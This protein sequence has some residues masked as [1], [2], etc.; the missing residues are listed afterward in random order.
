[1]PNIC[2]QNG[3]NLS[4]VP[5][6]LKL[7][8]LENQLIS[9]NLVFIKVHPSPRSRYSIMTNR[10][11]NVPIPD[12]DVIKTVQTLPRHSDSSGLVKVKLKRKL[13]YKNPHKEEIVRHK[14]LTDAVNYL[15]LHHSSY[16]DVILNQP[17]SD[18][19]IDQSSNHCED[20]NHSS[21][22]P[23]AD[24]N[25]YA[26]CEWSTDS[27][28]D[29]SSDSDKEELSDDE[30]EESPYNDVTCLVPDEPQTRMLINTSNTT[31]HKKRNANSKIS[32]AIAP[33]EGKC[34][35]NWMRDE[36]FDIDAFPIHHGDAKY[37]L[38]YPRDIKI[39]PYQYF[40]QRLMNHDKRWSSDLSFLF[41]GQQYVERFALEREINLSLTKGSM[42]TSEDKTTVIPLENPINILKKIPGTPS[43]WKVFKNDILAKIEQH[44][45][46]H[47]FNTLPRWT[48]IFCSAAFILSTF[49]GAKSVPLT[50]KLTLAAVYCLKD[51]LNKDN[52]ST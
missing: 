20:M 49:V 48:N 1:M 22:D 11:V 12:D 26:D 46:F 15:R 35:S 21:T 29:C 30:L 44:G 36:N 23:L 37:G 18:I 41:V 34:I 31:M 39:Q 5:D 28:N 3:L 7:T 27:E 47:F 16:N 40:T 50:S 17:T 6:C 4:E 45:H 38:N 8:D 51:E 33:G 32:H 24:C 25:F 42:K 9:K 13:E 43:Y 2:F 14:I 10:I 52:I 19:D